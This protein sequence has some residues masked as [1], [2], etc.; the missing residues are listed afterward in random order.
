[1]TF[2]G[3]LPAAV[4]QGV[5]IS[6]QGVPQ[7]VFGLAS[8]LLDCAKNVRVHSNAAITLAWRVSEMT[9]AINAFNA[10]ML[11]MRLHT[12]ALAAGLSERLEALLEGQ[13]AH[14]KVLAE[15]ARE[16]ALVARIPPRPK[17]YFGRLSETQSVVDTLLNQHPGRVAILGGPGMGKTTLSATVL[18]NGAVSERFGSRRFF[19]P[20]DALEGR[21]SCMVMISAA[22]G[23]V[24]ADAAAARVQVAA[25]I[26]QNP[27]LLVL[28]NFES[29]WDAPDQR[30]DAE[31]TLQF[32]DSIENVSL[33]LTMRGA[34]RP[35]GVRW[36]RPFL[37]PLSPISSAAATQTFLSISGAPTNDHVME[38]LLGRMDNIPLA[39]VLLANLAQYESP[40]ELMRRWDDME[41][42]LLVRGTGQHRLSSLNMS[43]ELSLQ[44]PRMQAAPSALRLLSVLALLPHGVV[45]TDLLLWDFQQSAQGLS[46][47]LQNSLATC[48][49]EKRIHVLAPIRS[50]ILVHNP[51]SESDADPVYKYV[52][53]LAALAKHPSRVAPNAQLF[54]ALAAELDNIDF[55]VRYALRHSQEARVASIKAVTALCTLF[56][57]AA[58][59]PAPEL[60]PLALSAAQ[61]N[62][63][64]ELRAELLFYWGM[65]SFNTWIPG[66]PKSLYTQARELY[67]RTGNVDGMIDSGMF[68]TQFLAPKE[69]IIEA[70]R[71]VRLSESRQ[72]LQRMARCAQLLARALQRD[73]Q[74]MEAINANRLAIEVWQ[75]QTFNHREFLGLSWYQIGE[76]YRSLGNITAG[77]ESYQKALLDFEAAKDPFGVNII[78]T[79][80]ADTFVTSGRPLEAVKHAT[81]A[82]NVP[83]AVE[84]RTYTRCLVVLAQGHATAGNIT[85]ATTAL[86]AAGHL[87][88]SGELSP[89]LHC[90]LLRGR[91]EIAFWCG[92]LGEA[93]ALLGAASAKAR[94]PDAAESVEMMMIIDANILEALAEVEYADG[95]T[96]DAAILTL[97]ALA[98]KWKLSI[99]PAYCLVQ[100]AELVDDEFAELL[101]RAALLPLQQM[102]HSRALAVGLLRSAKIAVASGDQRLARHRA[103]SALAH[104]GDIK[105]ERRLERAREILRET[106]ED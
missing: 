89:A 91:G 15:E 38:T 16:F 9:A 55:V 73:G 86:E 28:D 106:W 45:D 72:D 34:E 39:V 105:D 47:L 32:I 68:E 95:R 5:Q 74:L 56:N 54:S 8:E 41:T 44:S 37:P 59:G 6:G 46:V 49:A 62:N 80:L 99:S 27:T 101:L 13:G 14:V 23:I 30:H 31:N 78:H 29:A 67:E 83:R 36:T 26:G 22:L 3:P 70:E 85:A 97:C 33:I 98:Y 19:I 35:R 2:L 20:C 12:S 43:I 48:T 1:M 40:P 10:L 25:F 103:K 79:Q 42:A 17:F 76:L 88:L 50:F 71:L 102:G 92:N 100:L 58:M 69:A 96:D 64:D 75:K 11:Q 94:E 24:A 65:L 104:F 51:P 61:D 4:E 81:L 66:D 21:S 57:E 84:F 60:L 93:R 18:H 52:F 82:L 87:L 90:D 53:G 63:L 77:L 7:A